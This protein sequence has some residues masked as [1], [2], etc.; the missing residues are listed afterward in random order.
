MTKIHRS[1]EQS[2]AGQAP[3]SASVAPVVFTIPE[4]AE[5]LKVSIKTIYNAL[6][7][8]KIFSVYI[9]GAR[10]IPGTEIE[11]LLALGTIATSTQIDEHY[12]RV[13]PENSAWSKLE[14][15]RRLAARREE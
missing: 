4:A 1:T 7:A 14:T 6:N 13:N 11:R 2:S 8:G 12:Q 5:I 9:L 3:V 15:A 10:R